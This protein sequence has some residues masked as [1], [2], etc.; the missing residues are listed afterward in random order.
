[1]NTATEVYPGIYRIELPLPFEL[2]SV[3]VHLVRL[4]Q[5]YMLLDCGL[6]TAESFAALEQGIASAG[7]GW[8]DIRQIL[9]THTHP[10]HMGLTAKVLALTGAKLLLHEVEAEQ[11]AVVT[12]PSRRA[13]WIGRAFRESGVPESLQ[14]RMDEHFGVIRR[15]FY[16]L[17]PD[18]LL[19]G[20]ED[21][22][23]ALGPLRV[24]WTPGHAPGHI[25]LHSLRH[26]VLIAGDQILPRITPNISWI[27]EQD[28]LADFLASL[29]RLKV[30]EAGLI[31]PSHGNPF[32]GHQAWIEKT[33][34]HHQYRCTQM[35]ELLATPATAHALVRMLWHR[36]L[37]PINHQFALLEVMA[38]LTY[39][40][41]RGRLFTEERDGVVYWA[42]IGS[43]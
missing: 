14:A 37:S 31:L 18:R 40:Q 6:D 27:P 5:G 29:E 22:D 7:I 10:D 43:D 2:A 19:R 32:Q 17:S 26:R 13:Q 8:P 16:P 30:L 1:M 23:T 28:T 20:G 33:A 39:M 4:D 38:H 36:V 21:L 3:N 9:L 25:C 34:S 11:L 15:N 35:V 42:R 12:T 24:H 41:R